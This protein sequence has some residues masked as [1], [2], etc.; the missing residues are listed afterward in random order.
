MKIF[1]LALLKN[2][3]PAFR[4]ILHRSPS[5]LIMPFPERI[6]MRV[7]RLHFQIECSDLHMLEFMKGEIS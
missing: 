4:W 5:A 7:S 2:R 3:N 1:K 6:K